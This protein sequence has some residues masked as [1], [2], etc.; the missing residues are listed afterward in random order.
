[1]T[2]ALMP[3][4]TYAYPCFI[5]LLVLAA[6]GFS[7]RSADRTAAPPA[8]R[9][10]SGPASAVPPQV[11]HDLGLVDLGS[12]HKFSVSIPNS[13]ARAVN[14]LNVKTDCACMSASASAA[15]TAPGQP[16]LLNVAYRAAREPM[17]FAGQVILQT[18]NPACPLLRAHIRAD[19]GLPV[20]AQDQPIRV[21]PSGDKEVRVNVRVVNRGKIPVRLLYSTSTIPGCLA[22]VPHEPLAPGGD[23][24]VPV[25]LVAKAFGQRSLQILIATDLP[26]QPQVTIDM[27]TGGT[28]AAST[29]TTARP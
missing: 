16:F 11:R 22:Q 19:V 29:A 9:P 14:I 28:T 24:T 2:L 18:D 1:M 20:T 10:A 6:A 17:Q 13:S 23:V 3:R 15:Q 8:T 25:T 7:C 27:R 26:E 21:S 5:L 12:S 4:R